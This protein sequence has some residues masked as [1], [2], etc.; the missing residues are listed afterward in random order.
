[1][2]IFSFV[3]CS[4]YMHIHILCF[5]RKENI[6]EH[7]R[8]PTPAATLLFLSDDGVLLRPES[9]LLLFLTLAS[10]VSPAY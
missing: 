5:E 8:K 2:L 4:I 6:T 9:V 10:T 3:A 7:S 1:M